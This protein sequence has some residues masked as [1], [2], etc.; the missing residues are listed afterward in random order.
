MFSLCV[1]ASLANWIMFLI[2]IPVDYTPTTITRS[3]CFAYM[4]MYMPRDVPTLVVVV[5]GAYPLHK[6]NHLLGLV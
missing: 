5:V 6:S 4:Y 2:I 1:H 3:L